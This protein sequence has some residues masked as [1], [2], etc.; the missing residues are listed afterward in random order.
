MKAGVLLPPAGVSDLMTLRPIRISAAVAFS[1]LLL[2][3]FGPAQSQA[4]TR[5]TAPD[6]LYGGI[7]VAE[8]IARIND[9]IISRA[10]YDRAMKELDQELRQHGSSMQE[11]SAAHKDLLRNLIDQQLWLSKGKQ[12]GI[13]GDTELITRL[14]EIRKQ[15]NLES[16]EDL[17]KAAKEQGVSFEDFKANIRNQIIISEVM[18]KTVGERIRFTPGE[19]LRYYEEHKQDYTKPESVTLQEILVSTGTPVPSV[20]QKGG[21]EPDDPAKVEAAQHKAEEIEAKLKAGGDFAQLA[22]TFSDGQTAGE[23]GNLGQ[24]QR[25]A[26][27]KVLEDATFA[28]DKGGYTAPIRTRQGYVILK[29]VEHVKNGAPEFKDVSGQV[30]EAMFMARMEPAMRDVLTKMREDSFIDI[31]TGYVDSGASLRQTKPTYSAYVPPTTKKKKKVERTRFRE[32]THFRQK[33]RVVEQA[34]A[35]AAT[36]SDKNAQKKAKKAKDA[37]TAAMKPGRKEKIRL[38]RAPTA[39]LPAA[40]QA[41]VVE[42]AGASTSA[43]NATQEVEPVNPLEVSSRPDHK[44]RFSARAKKPKE[45]KDKR[46]KEQ[47]AAAEA[48]TA[49]DS[50]EVSDRTVQ[51]APLGLSGDTANKKKKKAGG[52]GEKTRLSDEK[53]KPAEKKQES[54]D[55]PL[56]AAPATT[57]KP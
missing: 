28:L 24:Y 17:E 52:T 5:P 32:T 9:Q 33:T 8:I 19:A 53:K 46:S 44:V 42:D 49:P 48:P 26:L 45:H 56:G 51:S 3:S 4:Q 21:V 10:D 36:E 12:L 16:L 22:R 55:Q 57:P 20:S 40:S 29:V 35:P 11:I 37:E 41:P 13:T 31:K 1:A 2:A 18:R 6:S 38:G 34:A 27:A 25:G 30:E 47:K 39:T 54:A 43:S 15:Y 7:T 50:A 14:N 23:G